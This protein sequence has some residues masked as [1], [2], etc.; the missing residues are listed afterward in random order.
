MSRQVAFPPL[1]LV[2][3]MLPQRQSSRR[4]GWLRKAWCPQKHKGVD[5][6]EVETDEV[7]EEV[8]DRATHT[9]NADAKTAVP[10]TT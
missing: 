2:P 6:V 9:G 4:K 8:A 1:A 3:L 10:L 7:V 5:M